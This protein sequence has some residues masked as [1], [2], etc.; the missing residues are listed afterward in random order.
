MWNLS[1]P[2]P[3]PPPVS[4]CQRRPPPPPQLPHPHVHL[5]PRHGHNQSLK[6][7]IPPVKQPAQPGPLP[8]PLSC[9]S[10]YVQ[11]TYQ[12]QGHCLNS[13]QSPAAQSMTKAPRAPRAA[14]HPRCGQRSL[15]PKA[16]LWGLTALRV[17][18]GS[19]RGKRK[20]LSL[21]LSRCS[22]NIC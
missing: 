17:M 22:T 21:A 13:S 1:S 12:V 10:K 2:G 18:S 7:V 9:D 16:D 14:C 15:F 4:P 8:T 20:I 6:P 19:K 5:H 3:A 11:S